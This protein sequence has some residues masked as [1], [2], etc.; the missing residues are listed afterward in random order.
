VRVV[1]GADDG[2]P[3]GATVVGTVGAD[4]R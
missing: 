2:I 3:D 4:R 1:D